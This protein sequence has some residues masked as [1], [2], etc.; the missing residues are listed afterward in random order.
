MSSH[1]ELDWFMQWT[2]LRKDK[3]LLWK[4]DQKDIDA[5]ALLSLQ[6]LALG[7]ASNMAVKKV[8]TSHEGSTWQGTTASGQ[9]LL[10]TCQPCTPSWKRILQLYSSLQMTTAPVNLLRLASW[11]IPSQNHHYKQNFWL[12][13]TEIIYVYWWIQPVCLE[14]IC[15]SKEKKIHNQIF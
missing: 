3:L 14:V 1:I 9:Q 8:K 6:L 4:L 11:K 2:V 7:K 13:E 12:I 5:S 15:Y 10:L